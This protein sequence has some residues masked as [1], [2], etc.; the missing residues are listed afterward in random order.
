MQQSN[1]KNLII[2]HICCLVI[3]GKLMKV[4][5]FIL[6]DNLQIKHLMMKR[7]FLNFEIINNRIKLKVDRY[8]I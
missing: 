4:N 8:K 6:R 2:K 1:T 3:S 5:L 7:I